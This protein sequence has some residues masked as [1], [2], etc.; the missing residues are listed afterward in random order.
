MSQNGTPAQARPRWMTA[1]MIICI[2]GVPIN[3]FRDLFIPAARDV[4]VW[5]GFEVTGWAAYLTAPLHW[6]I[7]GVG[8]WGFWKL[9]PWMWP[10]ASLY[11]FYVAVAHLVWSEA[12]ANGRGW[13]IGLLQ[14][15]AIAVVAVALWRAR[16]VFQPSPDGKTP[17]PV[18]FVGHA[19]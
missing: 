14:A 4:E 11:V 8:A 10:W 15:A 17:E 9:R 2:A 13:P 19:P 12:S 6:A 7:L 16:P 3:I 1:L 5:L 18:S